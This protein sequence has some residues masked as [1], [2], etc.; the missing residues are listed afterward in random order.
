MATIEECRA[1][2]QRL[3]AHLADNAN[4]RGKVD[5]NRR[6]S[7]EIADLGTGFH[8]RLSG[9]QLVD[10][11]EGTDP[12]AKI[13]LSAGSDDLIGLVD[14]QLSFGHA[15]AS[16]RVSVKASVFDLMKLRSLL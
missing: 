7:V 11:S 14:G 4:S 13:K 16:G 9:G 2:V 10:I 1:A 8:G 15:W 3:A 5:L 12:D 6:I